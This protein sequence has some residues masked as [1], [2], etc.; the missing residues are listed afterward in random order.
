[1]MA[2]N[3]YVLLLEP[4]P[5]QQTVAKELAIVPLIKDT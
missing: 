5:R 3:D 1:M 2:S 4:K